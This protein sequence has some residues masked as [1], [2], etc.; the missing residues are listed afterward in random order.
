MIEESLKGLWDILKGTDVHITGISETEEREVS[1]RLL[2]NNNTCKPPKS[3]QIKEHP[4]SVIQK[5]PKWDEFKKL[6]YHNG[7]K[8]P[9]K[10]IF[11]VMRE[12][13][14]PAQENLYVLFS[15]P[16]YDKILKKNKEGKIRFGS[17]SQGLVGV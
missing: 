11:K 16:W 17:R 2:K 12:R 9:R 3:V 1:K 6:P 7:I 5:V 14:G 8:T 15:F 4:N 10:C 13:I